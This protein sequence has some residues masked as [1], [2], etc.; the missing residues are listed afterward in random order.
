MGALGAR[1][2]GGGANAV[3]G[4]AVTFLSA[5]DGVKLKRAGG[6][7]LPGGGY[8]AL[9]GSRMARNA[10]MNGIVW[11]PASESEA[12]IDFSWDPQNSRRTDL[13]VDVWLWRHTH[14]LVGSGPWDTILRRGSNDAVATTMNVHDVLHLL[15]ATDAVGLP[16]GE[17]GS[18]QRGGNH[19]MR[20]CPPWW[21]EELERRSSLSPPLPPYM[22]NATSVALA[23]A[24]SSEAHI[25]TCLASL[26]VVYQCP[27]TTILTEV[28]A[29][30]TAARAFDILCPPSLRRTVA[31]RRVQKAA[32]Q[33]LLARAN[34]VR[35][36][37]CAWRQFAKMRFGRYSRHSAAH[38][39]QRTVRVWLERR[40]YAAATLTQCLRRLTRHT[41]PCMRAWSESRTMVRRGL[42]AALGE[43]M[44]ELRDL[45][46]LLLRGTRPPF[47]KVATV[48]ALPRRSEGRRE[49]KEMGWDLL[50][51]NSM[52]CHQ[53]SRRAFPGETRITRA[54]KDQAKVLL[55]ER[56]DTTAR[57]SASTASTTCSASSS[58]P[59]LDEQLR[60]AL[61]AGSMDGEARSALAR[62]YHTVGVGGV[63]W[64]DR[65][66]VN[67]GETGTRTPGT[68]GG[69]DVEEERVWADLPADV[70]S[71]LVRRRRG[72][73]GGGAEEEGNTKGETK[74]GETG[75]RGGGGSGSESL[76][77]VPPVP[78]DA[79][80]PVCRH[81][82]GEFHPM[83][84]RQPG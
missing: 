40:N 53:V 18:G 72:Q 34:A 44:E 4:G 20:S 16:Y 30:M 62:A 35:A 51:N 58:Y 43:Y 38:V 15:H 73:E 79:R 29:H 41:R 26:L 56:D 32:R 33:W 81:G 37:G 54:T 36:L 3:N 14:E 68:A 71:S 65:V 9:R 17:G 1:V 63:T 27:I 80:K 11:A 2:G 23:S 6:V 21:G 28:L 46:S 57:G 50:S 42:V 22:L 45:S 13:R 64:V 66:D 67:K 8:I 24:S 61:Q 59:H 74:H 12:E 69:R 75:E 84:I 83:A 25:R 77:A 31:V 70:W 60:L 7:R 10:S 47:G 82:P 19:G 48:A 39:L 52:H 49:E 5:A 55:V 78:H 76:R